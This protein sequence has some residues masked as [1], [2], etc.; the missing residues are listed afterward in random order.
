MG[1]GRVQGPSLSKNINSGGGTLGEKMLNPILASF[2]EA[3]PVKDQGSQS[4]LSRDH[5][6]GPGKE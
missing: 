1:V 4:Q 6:Y 2:W 3:L 5:P